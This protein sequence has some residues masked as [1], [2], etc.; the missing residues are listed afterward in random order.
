MRTI[1]LTLWNSFKSPYVD[2]VRSTSRAREHLAERGVKDVRFFYGLD[3]PRSKLTGTV[4]NEGR[5]IDSRRMGNWLSQ[6]ALWAA[7]LLLPDE[8][9]LLLEDDAEFPLDWEPRFERA[10]RDAGDFE[11]LF[12]GSCCAENKPR[13]HI[14]GNVYEVRWPMC[15]HAYVVSGHKVLEK[16]IDVQ[17]QLPCYTHMDISMQL[18][19]LPKL[20]TYT[21]LPRI[22]GQ[23]DTPDLEP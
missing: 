21:V 20:R 23:F 3:G 19:S 8:P 18:H 9:M 16:L 17:D 5:L 22:V 11:I 12:I 15:T 7:C 2:V 14:A 6:R 4:V 1:C 10:V 13:T